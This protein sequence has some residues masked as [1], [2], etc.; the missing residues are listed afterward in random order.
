MEHAQ[1]HGYAGDTVFDPVS[2]FPW[3]PQLYS[4]SAEGGGDG[5][6]Q[7]T[8]PYWHLALEDVWSP[9]AQRFCDFAPTPR[10]RA[11]RTLLATLLNALYGSSCLG[12]IT[13][14]S[15]TVYGSWECPVDMTVLRAGAPI[16]AAGAGPRAPAR[17]SYSKFV[18]FIERFVPREPSAPARR[19]DFWVVA[20]NREFLLTDVLRGW[21]ARE[22][23]AEAA[24]ATRPWEMRLIREIGDRAARAA[25]DADDADAA[26]AANAT[27]NANADAGAGVGAGAGAAAAAGRTPPGRG[28]GRPPKRGP[29]KPARPASAGIVSAV[30]LGRE[31]Q[32]LMLGAHC[33]SIGGMLK[34]VMAPFWAAALPPSA[35]TPSSATKVATTDIA[36][37]FSRM[38]GRALS[39]LRR[40]DAIA[41]RAAFRRCT[42]EH[43]ET[44]L[45]MAAECGVQELESVGAN[46]LRPE[47]AGSHLRWSASGAHLSFG[48]G[49][50]AYF[51]QSGDDFAPRKLWTS[52]FPWTTRDPIAE[53]IDEYASSGACPDMFRPVAAAAVRNIDNAPEREFSGAT[54]DAHGNT[55]V[56]IRDPIRGEQAQCVPWQQFLTT[57][58]R[59]SE[60]ARIAAMA[61]ADT[62]GL[63]AVPLG[64]V[65]AIARFCRREIGEMRMLDALSRTSELSIT[66]KRSLDELVIP[67]S[68][69]DSDTIYSRPGHAIDLGAGS[70]MNGLD[71]WGALQV[72]IMSQLESVED[73]VSIHS[74]VRTMFFSSMTSWLTDTYLPANLFLHSAHAKSKS[75]AID[76]LKRI[77]PEYHLLSENSQSARAFTTPVNM[78]FATK[79][80]EEYGGMSDKEG[81]EL[82]MAY[83]KASMTEYRLVHQSVT[84]A[85]R[86]GPGRAGAHGSDRTLQTLDIHLRLAYIAAT[87]NANPST[88]EAFA[89]RWLW[90]PIQPQKRPGRDIFHRETAHAI[91]MEDGM[92]AGRF[93]DFMKMLRMQ[94]LWLSIGVQCGALPPI[95]VD[96]VYFVLH[97]VASYLNT[98]TAYENFF[99]VRSIKQLVSIAASATL[100]RA[101]FHVWGQ[102]DSPLYANA[103]AWP[104]FEWKH[105]HEAAPYLCAD[106][107]LAIDV[108]TSVMSSAMK[109]PLHAALRK[110]AAE[111]AG[112]TFD[113]PDED[114][115]FSDA[116]AAAP[117]GGA[118]QR[119]AMAV[120]YVMTTVRNKRCVNPNY[121]DLGTDMEGL[122]RLTL[123][124][125]ASTDAEQMRRGLHGLEK[126][127]M[128]TRAIP[129]I[130]VDQEYEASD[131]TA[132]IAAHMAARDTLRTKDRT[133]LDQFDVPG[134]SEKHIGLLTTFIHQGDPRTALKQA[135]KYA[136]S[137]AFARTEPTRFVLGFTVPKSPFILDSIDVV[138]PPDAGDTLEVKNPRAHARIIFDTGPDIDQDPLPRNPLASMGTIVLTEHPEVTALRTHLENCGI[139]STDDA[140]IDGYRAK[141]FGGAPTYPEC[142][143][144]AEDAMQK[145]AKRR[146]GAR[147]AG[148]VSGKRARAAPGQDAAAI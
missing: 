67:R 47:Q 42:A 65:R 133:V 95:N 130:R 19:I 23:D 140:T 66:V 142:F 101:A 127:Y 76:A 50:D 113:N 28:R 58:I 128:R 44:L 106:E 126:L 63:V 145:R 18:L 107:A 29:A 5:G 10:G 8:L 134:S 129:Y 93:E 116:G 68:A 86:E 141:R 99:P 49:D 11:A 100:L 31:E 87:N 37:E 75:T 147:D 74:L 84:M 12:P 91:T 36:G 118:R 27:A 85:P 71:A 72:H 105:I 121:L 70:V 51:V 59:Y 137:H 33:T 148:D 119:R 135:A 138:R 103:D 4:V 15:A 89:D 45:T 69:P 24:S 40:G 20:T 30:P 21:L 38:D 108:V 90:P 110:V 114:P 64:P 43:P 146:L 81:K 97:R 6:V 34:S 131:H 82:Y 53:R 104:R 122:I 14:R 61:G 143:I 2:T 55:T 120:S 32:V 83:M 41:A 17:R 123:S 78:C 96:V 22:M 26:A 102:P 46:L 35:G 54:T 109:I 124:D 52:K 39:A 25:A 77:S 98:N 117:A 16:D 48:T 88:G 92:H 115:L 79:I 111:S 136:L 3:T 56:K 112:Y 1:D 125:S 7:H 9:Y 13:S 57:V 139:D 94:C 144:A 73:L 60:G 62:A 80:L 132:W